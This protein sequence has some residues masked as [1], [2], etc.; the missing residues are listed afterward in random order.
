MRKRDDTRHKRRSTLYRCSSCGRK[1]GEMVGCPGRCPYCRRT[2]FFTLV[3]QRQ[4]RASPPVEEEQL[5]K[6]YTAMAK[7]HKQFADMAIGS[8]H[9][10]LEK[11]LKDAAQGKVSKIDLATL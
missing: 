4:K 7:E 8:V 2:A 1:V 11:G 5:K 10:V 3:E 9:E 6:G